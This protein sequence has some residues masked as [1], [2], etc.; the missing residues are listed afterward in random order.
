[1]ID[2]DPGDILV[3][4]GHVSKPCRDRPT[5]ARAWQRACVV[6]TRNTVYPEVLDVHAMDHAEC[7]GQPAGSVGQPTSKTGREL[8]SCH[9]PPESACLMTRLTGPGA[10]VIQVSANGQAARTGECTRFEIMN[11]R[12]PD[13]IWIYRDIDIDIDIEKEFRKTSSSSGVAC[14]IRRR[15]HP[16]CSVGAWPG[17]GLAWQG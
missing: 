14:A 8:E 10:T 2:P 11:N 5:C 4:D 16:R 7:H 17:R 13:L 15:P 1:M 6:V 12:I 3:D 9:C